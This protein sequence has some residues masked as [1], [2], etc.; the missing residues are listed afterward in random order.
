MSL[1]KFNPR[2]TTLFL[3]IALTGALRVLFN[4]SS[5]LSPLT[6]FTPLGAM[7]LFGGAYFSQRGKAVGF[8]LLTLLVSDIVLQQTVFSQYSS[9][10]LYSGWYWVYGAFA[11][12][13]IT[14]RLL[15]KKV[16]ASSVLLSAFVCT[17]I[18]WIVTDFGVWLG[19]SIYPQTAAGFGACLV[20]AI[21]FELNFIAG[22]LVYSGIMF[23]AFEWL[24]QRNKQLQVA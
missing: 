12:M 21:P 4:F 15:I 7:A 3:F 17:L 20:A 19:S 24:Q 14:G 18:H 6:N 1:P 23:G 16:S 10:L 13:A 11:L 2:N 9:G 8:P 5:E 22:T